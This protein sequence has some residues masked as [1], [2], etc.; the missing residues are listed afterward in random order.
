MRNRA[1]VMV[2]LLAALCDQMLKGALYA[3]DRVL[4]PGVFA[5]R[6]TRNTGAA[7]SLLSRSPLMVTLLGAALTAALFYAAF[8]RAG[9]RGPSFALSLMA[10]GAL[11]N[12]LDRLFRGF[13]V[14]YAEILFIRFAVFNF[15]DVCLTA[16]AALLAFFLLRDGEKEAL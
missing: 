9:A 5:L 6:G 1:K 16:G 14:D 3:S 13:V 12:L 15:A 2:V 8:F 11:G 4:I 7:F 10:G